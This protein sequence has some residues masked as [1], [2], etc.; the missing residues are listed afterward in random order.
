M[1]PLLVRQIRGNGCS[2]FA[3]QIKCLTFFLTPLRNSSICMFSYFS[4][5]LHTLN[6][7]RSSK[8]LLILPPS[9]GL[10]ICHDKFPKCWNHNH[11]LETS[12]MYVTLLEELISE[13]EG[14]N[15]DL[16]NFYD[17]LG[18]VEKV[19]P[20]DVSVPQNQEW[21]IKTQFLV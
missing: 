7:V 5:S 3:K 19:G 4:N 20:S 12:N 6:F 18:F 2:H 8:V 15:V 17:S 21:Y 13:E 16:I 9:S 10:P 1:Q 11:F 14:L